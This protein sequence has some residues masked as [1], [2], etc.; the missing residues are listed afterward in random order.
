MDVCNAGKSTPLHSAAGGGQLELVQE[1]L[2]RGA[3]AT[4]GAGLGRRDGC[5][6]RSVEGSR[7]GRGGGARARQARLTLRIFFEEEEIS[8]EHTPTQIVGIAMM[9]LKGK[10]SSELRQL[11]RNGP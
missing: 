1:L 10:S 5:R 8:N 6:P 9:L 7:N 11:E 2:R 3:D 4:Q